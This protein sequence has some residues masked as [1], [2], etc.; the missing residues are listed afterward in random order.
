MYNG[1]FSKPAPKKRGSV[2]WLLLLAALALMLTAAIGGSLA[3]LQDEPA[4]VQN[5]FTPGKVPNHVE[6]KFENDVKNDV[7]ITNDG[8]VDAYIRAAVVVNWVDEKGNLSGTAP[9]YGTDYTWEMN[10]DG[11]K[12]G[13]DGYYYHL[14]PVASE[15]STGILFTECKPKSTTKGLHLSVE[16]MGQSIQA[17][18]VT[19]GKPVVAE[20]WESVTGINDDLTLAVKEA[21]A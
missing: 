2:K 21:A 20:L 3:W 8:N 7:M 16:I 13:A 12:L 11:W 4:V 14:A 15:G 1:K 5:T 17:L 9:V 18:G 10:M 6:E 19:G